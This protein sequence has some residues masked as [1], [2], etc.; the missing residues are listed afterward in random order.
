MIFWKAPKFWYKKP[1]RLQKI[2]L[3]PIADIYSYVS[4]RNYQSSYS[5]ELKGTKVIAVGGIT[6]G[7]SGK[8]M[9]VKAICEI[10]KSRNRKAAILSRGYGRNSTETLRVN[11]EI[12]SYRDVG[13]EPLLLAEIAP[14]FVGRDRF[15]SAKLAKNEGFDAFILD[16]GITQKFL[17]PDIKL[18]VVD[19]NQRFGNGEMFPLGPNRLNFEKIKADI[20][21]VVVIGKQEEKGAF[22]YGDIPVFLGEIL[23]DFSKIR[24]KII[25]FCG[26]GYP[27]KFFNSFGNF[28]VIERVTFPDHNPYSNE[29]LERLILTA[30][31]HDAQLITTEKDFIRVPT[32]YRGAVTSVSACITWV[33]PEKTIRKIECMLL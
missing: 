5:H 9:V 33:E 16:D 23:Q 30:K 3:K 18:V 1:S 19:D 8:T 10:L 17:K 14:V 2:I 24:E 7:G 32:K 29:D 22:N 25:I 13:D 15:K 4:T 21:G 11:T 6:V 20:D 12:H 31:I 27:D 26:I 28:E